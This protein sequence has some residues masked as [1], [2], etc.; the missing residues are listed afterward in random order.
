MAAFSDLPTNAALGTVHAGDWRKEWDITD[1]VGETLLGAQVGHEVAQTEF[2]IVPYRKPRFGVYTN[3][4]LTDLTNASVTPCGAANRISGAVAQV[5]LLGTSLLTSTFLDKDIYLKTQDVHPYET[6]REDPFGVVVHEYGHFADCSAL[7]AHGNMNAFLNA[8]TR[9]II[10]SDL[11]NDVQLQ[12][13]MR[14]SAES[15]ADLFSYAARGHTDYFTNAKANGSAVSGPGE[16]ASNVCRDPGRRCLEADAAFNTAGSD[17][18]HE[19]IAARTSIAYDWVDTF[20]LASPSPEGGWTNGGDD[21]RVFTPMRNIAAAF[22]D[23]GAEPTTEKAAL[24][25]VN[26]FGISSDAMCATFK[27]HGWADCPG[28]GQTGRLDGPETLVGIPDG[29]SVRWRWT[30]TS[31][32]AQKFAVIGLENGVERELKVVDAA[33]RTYG[34]GFLPPNT[35]ST[36]LIEARTATP[37]VVGR[38]IRVRQCSLAGLPGGVTADETD[39]GIVVAWGAARASGYRLERALGDGS[40]F[41]T[42]ADL[43]NVTTFTDVSAPPGVRVTYRLRATNCTGVVSAQSVQTVLTTRTDAPRAVYVR[44]GGDGDGG[45]ANPFGTLAKA[46]ALLRANPSKTRILVAGGLYD[47]PIDLFGGGAPPAAI[48]GGYLDSFEGR[49]FAN[50]A[51]RVTGG[52]TPAQGLYGASREDVGVSGL[53]VVAATA[54]LVLDGIVLDPGSRP[55]TT[56]CGAISLVSNSAET[57]LRHVVYGGQV[58]GTS[59]D[60][61]L[62]AVQNG[63][64]RVI[65]SDITEPQQSPNGIVRGDTV[66]VEGSRI[67]AQSVEAPTMF[68]VRGFG[69]TISADYATV[70]RS[71]IRQYSLSTWVPAGKGIYARC[72]DVRGSIVAAAEPLTTTNACDTSV[73]AQSLLYGQTRAFAKIVNNV[74]VADSGPALTVT[75]GALVAPTP[76]V[77]NLFVGP[78]V[79]PIQGL[80]FLD[81][82]KQNTFVA[83]LSALKFMTP[84]EALPFNFGKAF[85][86]DHSTYPNDP[87]GGAVRL[88]EYGI[89]VERDL[90]GNTR[91][92]IGSNWVGPYAYLP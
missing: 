41:E 81:E 54:P 7:H 42:L 23:I 5:G 64:L 2:G 25:L 20:G 48:F 6:D 19:K 69:P 3:A 11:K 72:A 89:S 38:S 50:H 22:G 87:F 53:V 61:P 55:C 34:S 39:A 9:L 29:S 66:L 90:D 83:S 37:G 60:L 63:T 67:I 14:Q 46:V 44:V 16:R 21:D 58:R 56:A 52:A 73:I 12:S 78:N 26:R 30:S 57:T 35:E 80:S 71:I 62:I 4:F 10:D 27:Q 45:R 76:I 84:V 88:E 36:V 77:R 17:D 31:A 91:Q 75:H 32:L 82:N 86:A 85:H 18:S 13:P 40:T 1:L 28:L 49:D 43:G 15:F 92:G 74:F 70:T 33:T 65:D 47:E 51:T 79:A 68:A 59:P 8:F 24:Y